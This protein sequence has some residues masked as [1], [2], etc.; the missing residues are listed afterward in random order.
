MTE[1]A[2]ILTPNG[3]ERIEEE[4]RGLESRRRRVAE[5]IRD[6]KSFGDIE[7]NQ[8]YAFARAEHAY[9]EG[10]IDELK[11]LLTNAEVV[12]PSSA[13]VDRIAIGAT[14]ALQDLEEGDDWEITLVGRHEADPELDR[15]SYESPVGQALLGRRVGDV[16]EAR[17][18][19]G[20]VRYQ[21]LEIRAAQ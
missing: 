6:A 21:V 14:V 13:D 10:R 18:P 7:E 15:I 16:V 9:V 8:E 11:R 3:V 4:L 5:Q 12:E 1:R 19:A 20:W 2:V 17:V